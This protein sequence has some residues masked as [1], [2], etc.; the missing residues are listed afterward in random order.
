VTRSRTWLGLLLALVLSS[1]TGCDGR[2]RAIKAELS[3]SEAR[4][5]EQG[6]RVAAGCWACHDLYGA[7]HKIGPYLSG[8]FGRR[9]GTAPGYSY[10]PALSG[11]RVV[12][13]ES[14]MRDF[15]ADVSGYLPGNRMAAPSIAG[16]QTLDAVVF[17][18]A[19]ATAQTPTGPAR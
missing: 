6:R 16:A 8:V 18:L 10:S 4:R 13:S 19:L 11:S 3:P 12:W 17:Y 7:N 5:F 15:L 14:T 1:P 2:A 9:A